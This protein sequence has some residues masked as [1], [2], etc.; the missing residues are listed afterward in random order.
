M[1]PAIDLS[2]CVTREEVYS[3]K[4]KMM[5]KMKTPG[6][7][8]SRERERILSCLLFIGFG[9]RVEFDFARQV[10]GRLRDGELGR[11]TRHAH[12]LLLLPELVVALHVLQQFGHLSERCTQRKSRI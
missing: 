10:S 3:L 12:R 6:S 1:A 7:Q 8:S 4:K 2:L 11:Q 9:E 5:M